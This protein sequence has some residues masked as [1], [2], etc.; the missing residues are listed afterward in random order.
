MWLYSI[1][2]K[3]TMSRL[4][5]DMTE[6]QHQTLKATAALQG[7][8]IKA[9]VLERLLPSPADEEQAHDELRALLSE[10]LAQSQRGELIP[11]SITDAASEV[12]SVSGRP[13]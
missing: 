13:S 4:T 3:M 12:S 10:R 1:V 11:G 5:I 8:S 2:D 9:Y 6:H 7:K